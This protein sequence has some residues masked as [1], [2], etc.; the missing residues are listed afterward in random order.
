MEVMLL[1]ESE[2]AFTIF[3]VAASIA[4]IELSELIAMMWSDLLSLGK[5]CDRVSACAAVVV[6]L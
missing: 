1:C 3:K 2:I 6:M 4:R 5:I